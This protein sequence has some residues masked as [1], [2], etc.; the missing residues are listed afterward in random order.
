MASSNELEEASQIEHLLLAPAP[1]CAAVNTQGKARDGSLFPVLLRSRSIAS[2]TGSWVLVAVR[3]LTSD[4]SLKGALHRYVT[5]LLT[6]KEALQQYNNDLQSLVDQQTTELRVAKERAED[7][8]AAQAEF[9]ANMSHELRTPL[10]GILSFA[11]FGIK[12][13]DSADAQKLL[14]YYQRIESAGQTL[15]KLLNALL[16]LSKL[17]SR[18]VELECDSISLKT[19]VY[20]VAEEFAAIL[21]EKELTLEVSPSESEALIWADHEKL[22]QVFRNVLGNS[23]KFTPCRGQICISLDQHDDT[24]IVSI[25]D[26]GPGIP[27]EDCERV[28]DKFVQ[29]SITKTGAGGTGLGLSICREIVRLHG[30][31]IR[32]VPTHG[33]GALIQVCLPLYT[34]ELAPSSSSSEVCHAVST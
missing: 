27:D 26:S 34:R 12:K 9:L 4:V 8:K 24:L 3:D 15:L 11:R 1:N 16:D 23:I 30:G 22:S 10:H 18:A 19:V 25:R 13:H 17:E 7:A 33:R 14:L 29:S 28:F 31:T 2:D 21:R 6:A 5:Q 32:A 20:D